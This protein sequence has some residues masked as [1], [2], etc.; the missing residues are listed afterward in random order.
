MRDPN[1]IDAHEAEAAAQAKAE[2]FTRA[3]WQDDI[4]WLMGHQQGRRIATRLLEESGVFRTSFHTSGSVMAHQEGRKHVGYYLTGELLEITPE[5]YF[6][7]L[8]EYRT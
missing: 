3:Q 7:L 6:R 8:K 4:K 5:G 2:E 1:D